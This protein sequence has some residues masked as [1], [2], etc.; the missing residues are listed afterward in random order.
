MNLTFSFDPNEATETEYSLLEE[1]EYEIKI[2]SAELK[3]S[4]KKPDGRGG[5]PMLELTIIVYS[6]GEER[7]VWDYIVNPYTLHKLKDVCLCCGLE[8]DGELDEDLLVGQVLRAAVT[9]REGTDGY[10]DKNEVAKYLA[11][12]TPSGGKA[13]TKAGKGATVGAVAGTDADDSVP[14]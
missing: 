6:D 14:F 9:I 3:T 10:S 4:K 1:G 2:R 12:S 13:K 5:N 11:P 7:T 8:F